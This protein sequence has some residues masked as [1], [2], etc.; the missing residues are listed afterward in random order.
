VNHGFAAATR[1]LARIDGFSARDRD[2]IVGLLKTGRAGLAPP[3]T[4]LVDRVFRWSEFDRWQAFFTAR[5]TFPRGWSG[6]QVVPPA[7]ASR[8]V[9][10]SYRQRKLELLLEWLNTL[11]Q[12]TVELEHYVRRGRRVR[13]VRQGDGHGCPVCDTFNTR[14]VTPASQTMPPLH[15]GCRC[16]LMAGTTIPPVKARGDISARAV[17]N[18]RQRA[19]WPSAGG[20]SIV[21]NRARVLLI[22]SEDVLAR[23]R[24]L[25]GKA[26]VK[27]KLPVSLQI[28]LRALIEEGLKRENHPALLANI[29]GHANAIRR[30]RTLARRRTAPATTGRASVSAAPR[31]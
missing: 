24:V 2:V 19:I 14:E 17:I 13:I 23:A 3:L 1:A 22:L 25:A 12:R 8:Q 10:G 27:L 31:R 6:L 4:G 7:G 28:I 30:T 5:G 29:E 18:S 9:S 21:E 16:V 26:T 20:G 15:P 11:T